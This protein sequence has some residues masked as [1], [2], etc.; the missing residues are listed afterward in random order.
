MTTPCIALKAFYY[1]MRTVPKDAE[2][3]I[4]DKDVQILE[5]AQAVKRKPVEKKRQYKRRDMTA[6]SP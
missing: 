5:M 2:C 3:E 4:E 6:E 1:A